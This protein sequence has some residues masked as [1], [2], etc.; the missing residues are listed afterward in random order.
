[1]QLTIIDPLCV[2]LCTYNIQLKNPSG[3][4]VVIQGADLIPKLLFI[5]FVY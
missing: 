3:A 1:M 2:S 5:A 4:T